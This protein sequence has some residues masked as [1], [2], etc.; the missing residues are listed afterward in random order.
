MKATFQHNEKQ[1]N[2]INELV[3]KLINT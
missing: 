3:N 2:P 1:L